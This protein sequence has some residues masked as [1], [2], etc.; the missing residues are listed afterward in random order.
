MIE[1]DSC[2]CSVCND[3][4]M[5]EDAVFCQNLEIKAECELNTN[6]SEVKIEK[7]DHQSDDDE[8]KDGTIPKSKEEKNIKHRGN[9]QNI[10]TECSDC[11]QTFFNE[12]GRIM[13]IRNVHLKEQR[14]GCRECEYKTNNQDS[15]AKHYRAHAGEKP[16]GCPECGIMVW[17]K[18]SL[19]L[20]IRTIH[21]KELRFCCELCE[22][23]TNLKSSMEW[24]EAKHMGTM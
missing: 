16:F 9:S 7:F 10:R 21:L 13:H 1:A 2:C 6:P 11:D 18:S 15:L 22:Y 20:H 8:V 5:M 23:K 4:K 17:T 24:H 19:S 12:S 3:H 14:Y